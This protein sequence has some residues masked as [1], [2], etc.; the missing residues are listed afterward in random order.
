MKTWNMLTAL[1][2][3]DA[4]DLVTCRI[5]SGYSDIEWSDHW[6]AIRSEALALAKTAL[7]PEENETIIEGVACQ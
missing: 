5:G 1:Q 3:S 2:Q 7:Y 4:L 6:D